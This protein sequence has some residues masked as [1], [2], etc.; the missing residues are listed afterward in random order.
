MRTFTIVSLW[1]MLQFD[2]ARFYR[3]TTML[4]FV[5]KG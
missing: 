4:G 2:A 5:D 3:I 1:E